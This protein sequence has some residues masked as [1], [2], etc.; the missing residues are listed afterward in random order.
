MAFYFWIYFWISR[1]TLRVSSR[2]AEDC[3]FR[4]P[5]VVI[6]YNPSIGR[7]IAIIRTTRK[8]ESSESQPSPGK[9]MVSSMA[10]P[11]SATQ[12]VQAAKALFVA[13]KIMRARQTRR[14]AM[15]D[16][17]RAMVQHQKFRM[18]CWSPH[19]LR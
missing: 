18:A 16:R 10:G 6:S 3:V 9:N 2:R 12:R 4:R 14:A 17:L 11:L 7:I 8:S 19:W 13:R 15:F 5:P 1:E